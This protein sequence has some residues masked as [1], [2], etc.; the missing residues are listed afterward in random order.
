[1]KLMNTHSLQDGE[2]S[3]FHAGYFF[4]GCFFSMQDVFFHAEQKESALGKTF[5][6]VALFAQIDI[7]EA[8]Y[9]K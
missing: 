7:T 6:V 5:H 1:M 3:T 4:S 2:V 8:I 9:A